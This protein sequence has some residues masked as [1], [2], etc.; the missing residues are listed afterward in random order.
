M[1]VNSVKKSLSDLASSD[2]LLSLFVGRA[3]CKFPPD[4]TMNQS[5]ID[6]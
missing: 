2:V 6:G 1:Y 5:I 3:L 4:D